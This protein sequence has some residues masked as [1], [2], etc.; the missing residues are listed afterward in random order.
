MQFRIYSLIPDK[1]RDQKQIDK[2]KFRV[3]TIYEIVRDHLL[4]H[5]IYHFY[6][7]EDK[8]VFCNVIIELPDFN[9][10]ENPEDPSAIAFIGDSY[11]YKEN[12]DPINLVD[13]Y[14]NPDYVKVKDITYDKDLKFD[15]LEYTVWNQFK[16]MGIKPIFKLIYDDY[17]L[18][19]RNK[20][21]IIN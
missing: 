13:M 19:S 1:E 10:T 3:E 6:K 16:G 7:H 9:L 5:E 11:S 15:T 4:N 21:D 8:T 2:I 14:I 17:N 18:D 20:Y 12:L